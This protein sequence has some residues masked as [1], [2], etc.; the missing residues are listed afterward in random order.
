MSYKSIRFYNFRNLIDAE[1]ELND[2]IYYLVGDNGAG[3][4]SFLEA[5]YLLSY[6]SSF[7]EKN[8]EHCLRSSRQ[9]FAI[10]GK[11]EREGQSHHIQVQYS[12]EHDKATGK[13]Q[14]S[15]GT[16]KI[17]DRRELLQITPSIV[18]AHGDI[19]Y[20]NGSPREKRQFI[21]Q[22]IS[23]V[24]PHYIDL[25]RN[26]MH[27]LAQRNLVLKNKQ[28]DLLPTYTRQ[29][30]QFG[31][32]IQRRRKLH[33]A[34]L[35]KVFSGL[36]CHVSNFPAPVML[37]YRPSWPSR[38][39]EPSVSRHSDAGLGEPLP[40]AV[41]QNCLKHLEQR[42]QRDLLMGSSQC[43]P[44]RDQLC[45]SVPEP[46]AMATDQ[47]AAAQCKRDPKET[48]EEL[49]RQDFTRLA[50]T[51]QL[52]LAALTLKSAQ[53]NYLQQSCDSPG[54]L[55]LDDVLLEMDQIRRRLFL[56]SLPPHQQLFF[57]LLPNEEYDS[58]PFPDYRVLKIRDGKLSEG[59][60]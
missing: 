39:F 48:K 26:Y 16:K 29:M 45:F 24:D 35:S 8:L 49:P 7:R 17:Q 38:L 18:F 4:S 9:P 32:E 36:F 3:K 47:V 46:G 56:A 44:H 21:D 50:S 37:D 41:M 13:K 43:G 60:L 2:N 12:K 5:L 53:A 22:T 34:K 11:I 52:R 59:K 33:I 1:I 19:T 42:Q 25:S 28:M 40:E 51:G 15:L 27:N 57:T 58:Y 55:L 30:V 23:L 20:I 10:A 31:L 14:I 54:V 6:G